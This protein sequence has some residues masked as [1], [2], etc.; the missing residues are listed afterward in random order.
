MRIVSFLLATS[1]AAC[2]SACGGDGQTAGDSGSDPT[3]GGEGC[4]GLCT[5]SGFASGEE[6]DYSPVIECVC[7]GGS[8][9][10]A[11]SDCE[12]YCAGFGV[13]GSSSFLS[14]DAVANDKC[15]CDGT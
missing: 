9:E 6:R 12:A 8:G 1:L 3:G 14:T 7:S 13:D 11:Q 10:I 15:V 2:L 5:S 4:A